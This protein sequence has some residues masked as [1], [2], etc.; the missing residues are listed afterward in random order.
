MSASLPWSITALSCCLCGRGAKDG[1]K[2][3]VHHQRYLDDD[4]NP[5]VGSERLADLTV[6]CFGCH[7]NYA[8]SFE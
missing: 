5:I 8:H 2:L 3:S 7:Q 4:G 6:L 1:V